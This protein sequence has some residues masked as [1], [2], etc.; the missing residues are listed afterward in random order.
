MLC[1][2]LGFLLFS[3]MADEI[4]IDSFNSKELQTFISH[5]LVNLRC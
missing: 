5:V 3:G 2:V 1:E 4:E